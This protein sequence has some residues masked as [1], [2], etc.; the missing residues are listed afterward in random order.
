M[1]ELFGSGGSFRHRGPSIANTQR[2]SSNIANTHQY[3]FSTAACTHRNYT[4][5]HT[6]H[7]KYTASQLKYYEYTATYIKDRNCTAVHTKHPKY[8]V[9]QHAS[10]VSMQ[11]YYSSTAAL[12]HIA[13]ASIASA[14]RVGSNVT[15]TQLRTSSI[16]IHRSAHPASQRHSE[17]S[18]RLRAYSDIAVVQLLAHIANPSIASTQRVS[19]NVASAQ[20]HAARIANTEVHI[21]HPKNTASQLKDCECTAILL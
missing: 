5:V 17:S 6:K 1:G 4:A 11:R 9:T 2:V 20:L 14:Q 8:T 12:A 21:K 7:R 15:N 16:A 19:S 13:D 3:C 18:Q 10:T